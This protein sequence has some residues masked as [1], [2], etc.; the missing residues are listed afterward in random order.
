TMSER[1][2]TDKAPY[3]TWA[4]QGWLM[5]FTGKIIDYAAVAKRLGYYNQRYTIKAI[6][7]DRNMMAFLEKELEAQGIRNIPLVEW[8]QGYMSMTKA[9]SALEEMILTG[10]FQHDNNPLLNMSVANARVETDHTLNRRFTKKHS[11]GR[12]DPL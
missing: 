12:I 2:K 3:G 10:T 7:Y 9:I 4:K 5:A 1:E 6:G 11:H 8:G